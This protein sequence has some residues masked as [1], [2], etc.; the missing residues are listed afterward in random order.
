MVHF[1]AENV[2]SGC[3]FKLHLGPIL[4]SSVQFGFEATLKSQHAIMKNRDARQA[5]VQ[6]PVQCSST[7]RA[8]SCPRQGNGQVG[9]MQNIV[10][11]YLW[12]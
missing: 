9:S 7:S 10:V 11:V 6:K 12:H 5:Y 2:L 8:V 3:D 1:P 4:L